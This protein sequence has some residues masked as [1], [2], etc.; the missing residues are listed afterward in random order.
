MLRSQTRPGAGAGGE[1][2]LPLPCPAIEVACMPGQDP[3][4]QV[5]G[6]PSTH[7]EEV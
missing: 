7:E 3:A 6:A 4:V 2:L 5:T 1:L